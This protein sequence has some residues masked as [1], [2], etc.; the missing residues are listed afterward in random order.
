MVEV[1]VV[2]LVGEGVALGIMGVVEKEVGGVG[3][4]AD[5][6]DGLVMVVEW[7]SW[8]WWRRWCSCVT[9]GRGELGAFGCMASPR[10]MWS[11]WLWAKTSTHTSSLCI[12]W[13]WHCPPHPPL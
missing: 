9:E 12:A 6:V 7:R 11:L 13:P 2:A 8:W 4:G 5:G 1:K 10:L 3:D